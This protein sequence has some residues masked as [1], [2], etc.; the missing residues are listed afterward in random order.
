MMAMHHNHADRVIELK[1]YER[2]VAERG[3]L[4]GL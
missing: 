3:V 1:H 2:E 4:P